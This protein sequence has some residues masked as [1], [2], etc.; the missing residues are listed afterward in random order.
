MSERVRQVFGIILC[1]NDRRN[2]ESERSPVLV[3]DENPGRRG[4]VIF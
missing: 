4:F 3:S 1:G 2:S